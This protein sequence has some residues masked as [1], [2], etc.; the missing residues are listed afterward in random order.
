VH[1]SASSTNNVLWAGGG[2][3]SD[4]VLIGGSGN[5]RLVAGPGADTLT[6]GGGSNGFILINGLDGGSVVVTDF[7]S[8]DSADLLGYGVG[9]ANAAL[10]SAQSAGGNTTITLSDNTQ[11]TFL[12][13]STAG[14][15]QGHLFSS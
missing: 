2:V 3:T 11:I 5:D 9:A 1:A 10:Q 8:S 4:D 7:N 13:V 14:A 6:G 12:G 15:L